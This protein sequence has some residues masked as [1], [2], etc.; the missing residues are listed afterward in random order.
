MTLLTV[1]QDACLELKVASPTSVI[2]NS[3]G[4]V[5]LLLA[6]A[7]RAGKKL[8]SKYAWTKLTKEYTFTTSN[9]VAS[10]VLPSDIDYE[11]FQTQWDRTNYWPLRGPESP[12]EWQER[13]SGVTTAAQRRGFRIKGFKLKTLFVEPTPTSTDTLVFEYQTRNWIQPRVWYEGGQAYADEYWS[14]DGNIYTANSN[15]LF[16]ATTPPTHTSGTVQNGSTSLTYY[17]GLFERFTH[18][19]EISHIDEEVLI[20]ELIWRWKRA[21]R[22]EYQ[23]LMQEAK[24]AADEAYSAQRSAPYVSITCRRPGNLIGWHNIPESGFGT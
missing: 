10:Y 15:G 1:I 7:Q 6:L 19:D 12:Q 21:N 13:Q 9:G 20:Q 16:S 8:R 18:D 23:D 14:Y 4:D 5:K 24:E 3:D 17:S 22:F 11:L 2:G